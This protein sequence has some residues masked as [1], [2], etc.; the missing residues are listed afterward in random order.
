MAEKFWVKTTKPVQ[1]PNE[2]VLVEGYF[3]KKGNYMSGKRYFK[4]Y[5]NFIYYFDVQYSFQL[6]KHPTSPSVPSLCIPPYQN[7][8]VFSD[9]CHHLLFPSDWNYE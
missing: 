8:S 5:N 2:P 7:D 4:L 6:S 9:I 1:L 3:S